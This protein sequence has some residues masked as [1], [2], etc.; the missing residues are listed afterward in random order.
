MPSLHD[1]HTEVERRDVKWRQRVLAVSPC[2]QATEGVG[3]A[4]VHDQLQ[5]TRCLNGTPSLMIL[6]EIT[7]GRLRWP[8]G[9]LH[10][11]M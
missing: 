3:I 10:E 6:L 8:R 1:S 11:I 4:D 2:M 9:Q 7:S 5:I